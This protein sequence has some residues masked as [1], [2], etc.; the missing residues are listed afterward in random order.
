MTQ[1]TAAWYLLL[2]LL[3]TV[4]G[5]T[6]ET[7]TREINV[8]VNGRTSLILIISSQSPETFLCHFRLLPTAIKAKYSVHKGNS[9]IHSE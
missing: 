3:P 6:K 9:G 7:L 5:G 8:P 1:T 4:D 2:F